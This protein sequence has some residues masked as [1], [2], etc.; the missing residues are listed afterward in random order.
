[1]RGFVKTLFGDRH[2]VAVVGMLLAVAA[3]LIA[4]GQ[5]TLA[6]YAVPLL[7]MAGIVWLALH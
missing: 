5:G 2:N 4:L 3:G 1:M 6:I 7:A